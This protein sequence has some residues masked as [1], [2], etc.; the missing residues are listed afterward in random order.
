VLENF[1]RLALIL[2]IRTVE[3][4]KRIFTV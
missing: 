2:P 3:T 4:G 1:H